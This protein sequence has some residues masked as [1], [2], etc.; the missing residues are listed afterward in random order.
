[1]RTMIAIPC[2]DTVQALFLSSCLGMQCEGEI[3]FFVV[4]GSLIY[5]ARNKIAERAISEKY[6]RVLWLDSDMVFQSDLF[7]RLSD[8]MDL[9]RQ[10]VTGLYFKRK[11]PVQPV[12]YSYCGMDLEKDTPRADSYEDYPRDAVFEIEACGMGGCMMTVD[13]LRKVQERFGCPFSPV[14]GFGEDFSFCQRVRVLGEQ[15]LCDSS[16]KL[17]HIAQQIITE[18]FYDNIRRAKT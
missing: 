10:M 8:H 9:G 2:G 5:D 14:L 17:G 18:G 7:R 16:I 12:I 11:A 1:M 6:D 15:I 13:L 4:S 3:N